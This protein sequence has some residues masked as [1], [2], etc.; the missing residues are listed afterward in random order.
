MAKRFLDQFNRVAENP[1]GAP[2]TE[3]TPDG[4][5]AELTNNQVESHGASPAQATYYRTMDESAHS[6]K[7]LV[8]YGEVG[9]AVDMNGA[10]L[11]AQG[12]NPDP[13]F[14]RWPDDCY[15]VQMLHP[16]DGRK[17][18]LLKRVATVFTEIDS[19]AL[20]EEL[21][22]SN[23]LL[24]MIV[25]ASSQSVEVGGIERLS[26]TD[27]AVPAGT[28]AGLVSWRSAGT[29]DG[30][31]HFFS[32][33][34]NLDL[35]DATYVDPSANAGPDDSVDV[36]VAAAL[37]GSGSTG[38][39]LSYLWEIDTPPGGGSGLFS[40][41]TAQSPTFTPDTVGTYTLKVTVT[42]DQGFSASDT[43]DLDV[44]VVSV[45][46]GADERFGSESGGVQTPMKGGVPMNRHG[47]G[48][49]RI[50]EGR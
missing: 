25:A 24:E 44:A 39:N 48:T 9:A 13:G 47:S 3:L 8:S 5:H 15:L 21:T 49:T 35:I 29:D 50:E 33:H 14:D 23:Q 46:G 17:L 22:T 11:M 18:R 12:S 1:L 36:D 34:D 2:Y 37:D 45:G 7:S 40:D 41:D 4:A 42:D 28:L 30:S 19:D 31:N 43:M 10:A 32:I 16:N 38:Q 27:S 26:A 20:N 6:V